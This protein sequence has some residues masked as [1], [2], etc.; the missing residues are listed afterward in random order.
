MRRRVSAI[1]Q[2]PRAR[3]WFD[4]PSPEAIRSGF[5]AASR[6]RERAQPVRGR[7]LQQG[8]VPSLAR[9]NAGELVA[10][11]AVDRDVLA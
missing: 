11:H 9:E 2:P 1:R 3:I 8:D 10:E 6:L 4:P 7:L 5:Q